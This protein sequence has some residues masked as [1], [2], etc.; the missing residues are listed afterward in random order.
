[1]SRPGQANCRLIETIGLNAEGRLNLID[2]FIPE[3]H[4]EIEKIRGLNS[5]LASS[6]ALL[7]QLRKELNELYE[8]TSSLSNLKQREQVLQSQQANFQ[9]QNYA[10]SNSQKQLNETQNNLAK[11]MVDIDNLDFIR[12]FLKN[13]VSSVTSIRHSAEL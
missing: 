13:K 5:I 7:I 2:S 12:N 10:V 4:E 8:K 11:L 9:K 6:S 3:I 1:L